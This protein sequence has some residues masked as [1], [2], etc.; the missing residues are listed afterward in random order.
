MKLFIACSKH[1]Y[2]RIP[3]IQLELESYGHIVSMP[4]SYD[5]PFR[6]EQMKARGLE[7]HVQWKA[8]MLRRNKENIEP[9]DGILVLNFEKNGQL[10]YIGGG[11]F[12][13]NIQSL[14][15]GKKI[16]SV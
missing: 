12:F 4:N 1:F 5:Q 10:N 13:R 15:N 3:E 16:I 8:D 11:N 9:N 14:G 7:A 2:H 6:E